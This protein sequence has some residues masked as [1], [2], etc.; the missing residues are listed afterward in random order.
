MVESAGGV[1]SLGAHKGERNACKDVSGLGFARDRARWM[2]VE[3]IGRRKKKRVEMV[4][5]FSCEP[6]GRLEGQQTGLLARIGT[7]RGA[8]ARVTAGGMLRAGDVMQRA[9]GAAGR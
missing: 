3:V 2:V 1:A 5:M 9:G 8:L 6:C 7:E 4:V